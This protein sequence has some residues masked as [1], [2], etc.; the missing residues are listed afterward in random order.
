MNP[1]NILPPDQSAAQLKA[2][3]RPTKADAE[4]AKRNRR[5]RYLGLQP[6]VPLERLVELMQIVQE[7]RAAT[8]TVGVIEMPPA[9][10]TCPDCQQA[11]VNHQAPGKPAGVIGMVTCGCEY[12][13]ETTGGMTTYSKRVPTETIDVDRATVAAAFDGSLPQ[14]V[15]GHVVK[16]GGEE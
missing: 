1:P 4:V 11:F 16:M 10:D 9:P 7:H 6:I 5:R 8:E 12:V 2:L 15:S 3:L 13:M 14:V